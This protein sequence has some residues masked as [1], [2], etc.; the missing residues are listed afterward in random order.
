[1]KNLFEFFVEYLPKEFRRVEL[2]ADSFRNFSLKCK[3]QEGWGASTRIQIASL[4]SIT[5]M[6]IF[7]ET[8]KKKEHLLELILLFFK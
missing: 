1:M 2:I 4:K 5:F 3:E 7:Y 6:Y 8:V